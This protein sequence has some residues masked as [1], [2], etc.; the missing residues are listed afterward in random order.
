MVSYGGRRAHIIIKTLKR[1]VEVNQQLFFRKFNL[2][3]PLRSISWKSHSSPFRRGGRRSLGNILLFYRQKYSTIIDFGLVLN[4][5]YYLDIIISLCL[6]SPFVQ[7]TSYIMYFMF[8]HIS[9]SYKCPF[10]EDHI[11]CRDVWISY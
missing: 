8:Y 11:L 1:P 4:C 10:P 2:S 3:I 5:Y 7:L 6:V 9:D